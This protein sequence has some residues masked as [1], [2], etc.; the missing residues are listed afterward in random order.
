MSGRL[1]LRRRGPG[2]TIAASGPLVV[3]DVAA[4]SGVG[5]R[6]VRG[7]AAT[8]CGKNVEA[9]AVGIARACATCA[10]RE[11]TS[12][13]DVDPPGAF[14]DDCPVC[15]YR[16]PAG[17]ASCRGCGVDAASAAERHVNTRPKGAT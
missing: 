15:G 14:P 4:R 9:K 1:A 10:R 5:H 8:L 12:Y 13:M 3:D 16:W 17:A 11:A 6:R 2:S 7:E